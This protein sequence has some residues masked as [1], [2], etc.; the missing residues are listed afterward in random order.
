[1]FCPLNP[2]V[3]S[4]LCLQPFVKEENILLSDGHKSESMSDLERTNISSQLHDIPA[5]P[6]PSILDITLPLEIDP[7]LLSTLGQP[8][9]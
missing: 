8:P 9:L 7:P 4:Q 1:M 2:H 6:T 5:Q 3:Y